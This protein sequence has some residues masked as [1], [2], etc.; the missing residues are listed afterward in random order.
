MS[1]DYDADSRSPVARVKHATDEIVG[2]GGG[3]DEVARHWIPNRHRLTQSH[4]VDCLIGMVTKSLVGCC[5]RPRR[6]RS[7]R[8]IALAIAVG[9]GFSLA[10][11]VA[12]E[13]IS[14]AAD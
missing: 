9:R 10:A 13:C 2:M 4:T 3:H 6:R 5:F 11:A 1:T 8:A 14:G 7:A 12:W